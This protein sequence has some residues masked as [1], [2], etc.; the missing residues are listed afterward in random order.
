MQKYIEILKHIDEDFNRSVFFP[1]AQKEEIH[2]FETNSRIRIPESY[3]KFLLLSNG[4]I[5]SGGDIRL[6][7][8]DSSEFP[9]GYDFSENA[10][11]KELIIL[12]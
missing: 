10:V 5:L 1:P 11:P 9:I 4:A 3:K 2:Q 6:Y 8:I 12:G 7:G